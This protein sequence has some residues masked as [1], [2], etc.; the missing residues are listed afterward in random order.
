MRDHKEYGPW[1][2]TCYTVSTQS[3]PAVT[4]GAARTV[5]LKTKLDSP[6]ASDPGSPEARAS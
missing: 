1:D 6:T 3:V 5:G 2:N 4:V